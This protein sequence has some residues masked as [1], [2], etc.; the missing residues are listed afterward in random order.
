[1][2]KDTYAEIGKRIGKLCDEKNVSYGDSINFTK[3]VL[4]ESFPDGVPRERYG[5]VFILIR[6]LDKVNRI[7]NNRELPGESQRDSA[8]DIAGYAIR[9]Y[10]EMAP[11]ED[12]GSVKER[13]YRINW[14]Y[15]DCC[16]RDF[17]CDKHVVAYEEDSHLQG[18]IRA[19]EMSSKDADPLKK[20]KPI[21]YCNHGYPI[22]VRPCQR[23]LEDSAGIPDSKPQMMDTP[24]KSHNLHH[25]AYCT[26]N[27]CRAK[28]DKAVFSEKQDP[29]VHLYSTS[30]VVGCNLCKGE[31]APPPGVIPQD[32]KCPTCGSCRK[33]GFVSC[34][35]CPTRPMGTE[36]GDHKL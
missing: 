23:C 29:H 11:K 8:A 22:S 1:M 4:Q 5:E 7:F 28:M 19:E 26:C 17:P 13:R 24:S 9:L 12:T 6:I 36:V 25:D 30:D 14:D 21:I 2:S 18:H 10:A 3:K 27:S 32:M 16:K 33:H 15:V 35:I 20:K 34:M 31:I